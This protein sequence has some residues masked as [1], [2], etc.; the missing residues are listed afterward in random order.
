MCIY[1]GRIT[2]CDRDI[3]PSRIFCDCSILLQN[4]GTSPKGID[5][6][7]A[8][9]NEIESHRFLIFTSYCCF[10]IS[11]IGVF[12]TI[13]TYAFSGVSSLHRYQLGVGPNYR[14]ILKS[15]PTS[16]SGDLLKNSYKKFWQSKKN[17]L[18]STISIAL[19]IFFVMPNPPLQE[20]VEVVPTVTLCS[21]WGRWTRGVFR[22]KFSK[23]Q[24]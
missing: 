19:R 12:V 22:T 5:Q 15:R 21:S 13:E 1:W 23:L 17:R 6:I 2:V 16:N 3:L 20:D 10:K 18:W 7:Q 4:H 9:Q 14:K 24:E 8:L 11:T